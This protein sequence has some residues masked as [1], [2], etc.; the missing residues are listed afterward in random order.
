MPTPNQEVIEDIQNK[1]GFTGDAL[2]AARVLTDAAAALLANTDTFDIGDNDSLHVKLSEYLNDESNSLN[3]F[4]I[5]NKKY[6]NKKIEKEI[7]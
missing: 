5:N 6:I 7:A 1:A 3:I 4:Q 2:R